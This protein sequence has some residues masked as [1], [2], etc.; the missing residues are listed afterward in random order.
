MYKNN[1]QHKLIMATCAFALATS[2]FAATYTVA[3]S[4]ATSTQTTTQSSI[5]ERIEFTIDPV[6]P[7]PGSQVAVTIEAYGIDLNTSNI[8]WTVDGKVAREGKGEKILSTTAGKEGSV[9]TIEAT[10]T[11]SGGET[12]KKR[13][14]INPQTVDI[15]WEARTYTP[16]FYKGKS[17]YTPYQGVVFDAM[18]NLVNINGVSIGSR[19]TIYK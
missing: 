8:S 9:T 11:P 12:I 10:I 1:W 17:A 14:F 7:K 16:P 3:T 2:A 15:I 6:Y 19:Q 4:T 18:P 13:F 5:N